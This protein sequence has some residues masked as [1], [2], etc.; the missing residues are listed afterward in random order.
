MSG[1]V[2]YGQDGATASFNHLAIPTNSLA[3]GQGVG[4]TVSDRCCGETVPFLTSINSVI[5][6]NDGRDSQIAVQVELDANGGTGNT[7]GAF[8]AHNKGVLDINGVITTARQRLR[9]TTT[10]FQ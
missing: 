10:L 4:I 1:V 7:T 6:H 5:T 8:I 3:T 2:I 9:R